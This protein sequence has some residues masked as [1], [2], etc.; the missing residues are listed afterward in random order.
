[1]HIYTR[2]PC[3]ETSSREGIP[4]LEPPEPR[5][6]GP[7]ANNKYWAG[8]G[9][10]RSPPPPF[11][12]KTLLSHMVVVREGTDQTK[13]KST[14]IPV[15]AQKTNKP[16]STGGARPLLDSGPGGPR[17]S[18]LPGLVVNVSLPAHRAGGPRSRRVRGFGGRPP[19]S[20]GP[21]LTNRN[22]NEAQ[23]SNDGT[24]GQNSDRA[25]CAGRK[26]EDTY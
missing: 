9:D 2:Q 25:L 3:A 21:S 17:R 22:R 6:S 26:P 15:F 8:P 16:A 20:G 10:P 7:E 13:R 11:P 12:G 4:R 23:R 19:W 5:A 1:M 14:S 24:N 18:N